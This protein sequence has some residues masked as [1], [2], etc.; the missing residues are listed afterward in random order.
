MIFPYS[1]SIF[2]PVPVL[3]VLLSAPAMDDWQGPLTAII[4]SGA[5]ISIVPSAILQLLNSQALRPVVLSSQWRD[6][7]NLY[8]YKVDIRV[9]GVIFPAID[10]AG[11][12]RSDDILLGRNVLNRL[13]MRLEGPV[14]RT[15]LLL[16]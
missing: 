9:D 13:D 14:L 1:T 11:D 12:P 5:D 2:P 4:D 15:H 3:E 8:I 6:R 7:H 16:D 10:V